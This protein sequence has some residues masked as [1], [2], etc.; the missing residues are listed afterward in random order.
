MSKKGRLSTQ[1]PR[2]S[3]STVDIRD[4][5]N[6]DLCGSEDRRSTSGRRCGPVFEL[7]EG[8]SRGLQVHSRPSFGRLL[9]N[10]PLA[11]VAL[12]PQPLVLFG[13]GAAAGALGMSVFHLKAA[14]LYP[15][16]CGDCQTPKP[17]IPTEKSGFGPDICMH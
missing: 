3:F 16:L 4:T 7:S 14:F 6:A 9:V 8:H 1:R 11:V 15:L 5:T 2:C 13:A 12:I 10:R 17:L